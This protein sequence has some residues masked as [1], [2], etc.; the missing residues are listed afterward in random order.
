M[1]R[2]IRQQINDFTIFSKISLAQSQWIQRLD[3]LLHEELRTSCASK[4]GAFFRVELII[5][6]HL[7]VKEPSAT[8]SKQ[9]H[10]V[11]C[12]ADK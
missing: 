2:T 7:S 1:R 3:S 4:R 6:S 11:P 10:A 8:G 12:R 9:T 5:D